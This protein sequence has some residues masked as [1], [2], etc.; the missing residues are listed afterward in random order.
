MRSLDDA[1]DD[2]ASPLRISGIRCVGIPGCFL[3]IGDE[4]RAGG[5][6]GSSLARNRIS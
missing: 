3:A 5:E 2:F 4:F 1:Q 6:A